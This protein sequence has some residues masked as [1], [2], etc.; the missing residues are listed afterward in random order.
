MIKIS[1]YIFSISNSF[2]HKLQ[3]V[4]KWFSEEQYIHLF[5]VKNE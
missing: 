5:N 2:K 4:P 3:E 1:K